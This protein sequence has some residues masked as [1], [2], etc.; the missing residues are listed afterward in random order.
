MDAK[1]YIAKG[2]ELFAK[3]DMVAY[4]DTIDD[5]IVFTLPGDSHPF[6][7][8]YKGKKAMMELFAKIPGSWNNF[9]VEPEFMISEGNK[10]F[11]K[12]I[13]KADGMD[14]IFGHYFEV[15]DEGKTIVFTA[16]DDTLSSKNAMI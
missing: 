14:T 8:V 11:V 13:A 1:E 3:G 12:V 10:V 16:H 6:S 9:S 4:F 2:Y 15:N 7:G 5:D